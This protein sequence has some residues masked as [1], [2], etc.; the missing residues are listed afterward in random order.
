[1][2]TDS[3]TLQM[4]SVIEQYASDDIP[5]FQTLALFTHNTMPNTPFLI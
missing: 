1:M 5:Q 4:K 3:D 2:R